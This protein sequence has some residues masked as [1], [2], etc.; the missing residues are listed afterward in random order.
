MLI[1][2]FDSHS[3]FVFAIELFK[4]TSVKPPLPQSFSFFFFIEKIFKNRK[5]AVKMST[6]S[7]SLNP[8]PPACTRMLSS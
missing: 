4:L 3:N 1:A 6:S 2:L 7:P 5:Y 8:P